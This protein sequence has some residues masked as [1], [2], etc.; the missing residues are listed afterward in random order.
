[1]GKTKRLAQRQT[2]PAGFGAGVRSRKF[3]QM[4]EDHPD[5]LQN[6]EF[7]LVRAYRENDEVDDQM[8]WQAV[9]THMAARRSDNE[10][11]QPMVAA[12]DHMRATR[13]DLNETLWRRG[14]Q[15]VKEAIRGASDL[16]EGTT[17]YLDDASGRV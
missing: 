8:A 16:Q 4:A 9:Q 6:I 5:V 12:L 14:L 7:A 15:A 13:V 1:M 3:V 10:L 2:A 17:D 11:V